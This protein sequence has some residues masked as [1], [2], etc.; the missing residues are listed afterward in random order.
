MKKTPLPDKKTLKLMFL[1][2]KMHLEEDGYSIEIAERKAG[3]S[4]CMSLYLQKNYP[5]FKEF[6]KKYTRKYKSN[7]FRSYEHIIKTIEDQKKKAKEELQRLEALEK[8]ELP[9]GLK[10]INQD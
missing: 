1:K 10:N 3:I 8:S 6:R 4:Q 5:G 9:F 7:Y 2:M